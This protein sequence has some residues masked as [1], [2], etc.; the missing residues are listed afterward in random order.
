M[1][2]HRLLNIALV[3]AF[4]RTDG[5]GGHSI[6]PMF[7]YVAVVDRERA[8]AFRIVDQI[9]QAL[10]KMNRRDGPQTIDEETACQQVIHHGLSKLK[11]LLSDRCASPTD[12][13]QYGDTLID[14]AVSAAVN[15]L[16]AILF[17]LLEL[18]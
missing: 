9:T 4:I 1:G 2:L 13:D 11:S 8:P 6:G 3:A 5:A 7:K 10:E 12:I 17:P 18:Y 15:T 14:L 16:S